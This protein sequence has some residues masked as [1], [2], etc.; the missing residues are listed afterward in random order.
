MKQCI[1][2]YHILHVLGLFKAK[3]TNDSGLI[4]GSSLAC[5]PGAHYTQNVVLRCLKMVGNSSVRNRGITRGKARLKV[6]NQIV[7]QF[8]QDL[9]P[10]CRD[11]SS[12]RCKVHLLY[13]TPRYLKGKMQGFLTEAPLK[14]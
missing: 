7:N 1:F 6:M 2:Y 4:T 8:R 13:F 9:P 10:C 3:D 11:L 12:P 5:P 14:T